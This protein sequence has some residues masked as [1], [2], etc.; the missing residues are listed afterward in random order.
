MFCMRLMVA[1]LGGSMALVPYLPLFGYA[2]SAICLI[3]AGVLALRG[4]ETPWGWFLFV[5]FLLAGAV[6]IPT[7]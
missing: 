6:K 5:G 7:S 1:A 4:K 3:Y 2:L